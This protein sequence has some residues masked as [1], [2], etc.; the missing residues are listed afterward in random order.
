MLP[1][2]VVVM[3]VLKN[4]VSIHPLIYYYRFIN[5]NHYHLGGKKIIEENV[6]CVLEMKGIIPDTQCGPHLRC[7]KKTRN[8]CDVNA[9][10]RKSKQKQ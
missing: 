3:N 1:L 4:L 7:V 6:D 9:I 10:C 5:N 8:E 2:V